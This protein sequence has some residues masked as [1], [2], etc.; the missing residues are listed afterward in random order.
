MYWKQGNQN[1]QSLTIPFHVSGT[2]FDTSLTLVME[3]GE[4][5]IDSA[6]MVL[7]KE[8][9]GLISAK[10]HSEVEYK[11]I[12]A[13]PDTSCFLGD[14]SPLSETLIDFRT[15]F[16]ESTS[17]GLIVICVSL[18]S[19]ARPPSHFF[20]EEWPDLWPENWPELWHDDWLT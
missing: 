8:H 5:F 1:I 17:D 9:S 11:S 12:G 3:A 20:H 13:L 16:P 18:M 7:S 15:S 19:S 6:L 10:R 14:F 4:Q 2:N